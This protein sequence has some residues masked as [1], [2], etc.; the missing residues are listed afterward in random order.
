MS[1]LDEEKL[2]VK[3]HTGPFR[4]TFFTVPIKKRHLFFPRSPSPPPETQSLPTIDYETG[5]PPTNLTDKGSHDISEAPKHHD[6]IRDDC[7]DRKQVESGLQDTFSDEKLVSFK[8]IEGSSELVSRGDLAM[9]EENLDSKNNSDEA[10]ASEKISGDSSFEKLHNRGSVRREQLELHD[11]CLWNKEKLDAHDLQK[12]NVLSGSNTVSTQSSLHRS[13]WDLNMTM[14]AWEES[15]SDSATKNPECDGNGGPGFS[16]LFGRNRPSACSTREE[17]DAS[18]PKFCEPNNLSNDTFLSL[19]TS[20]KSGPRVYN[21]EAEAYLDLCLKPSFIPKSNFS[22]KNLFNVGTLDSLKCL[23]LSVNPSSTPETKKYICGAVK[24]QTHVGI[25]ERKAE[26]FILKPIKSESC[27]I[28]EASRIIAPGLVNSASVAAIKE[29]P[30]EDRDQ[31]QDHSMAKETR[32]SHLRSYGHN[33]LE[34][35]KFMDSNAKPDSHMKDGILQ[36]PRECP[37]QLKCEVD[38]MVQVMQDADKGSKSISIN[39]SSNEGSEHADLFIKHQSEEGQN[40][41]LQNESWE[42]DKTANLQEELSI[43]GTLAEN[44]ADEKS[45]AVSRLSLSETD[46]KTELGAETYLNADV[47]ECIQTCKDLSFPFE[48]EECDNECDPDSPHAID[49]VIG[50]VFEKGEVDS[51]GFEDGELRDEA[52]LRANAGS[53][54]VDA[55]EKSDDI[56]SR[57]PDDSAAVSSL[58]ERGKH[59]AVESP[60]MSKDPGTV[61]CVNNADPSVAADLQESSSVTGDSGRREMG[62]TTRKMPRDSLRKDKMSEWKTKFDR[63][64]T[65]V[66]IDKKGDGS[67]AAENCGG[68]IESS[69]P[70]SSDSKRDAFTGGCSGRIINLNSASSRNMKR[71]HESSLSSRIEREKSADKSF[72]RQKYRF[73]RSRDGDP[74]VRY[75]KIGNDKQR[76]LACGRRRSGSVHMRVKGGSNLSPS[77][78]RD[79]RQ[80]NQFG[81]RNFDLNYT[82]DQ[83]HVHDDFR[84]SRPIPPSEVSMNSMMDASIPRRIS[85]KVSDHTGEV[86]SELG[87][88]SQPKSR[89]TMPDRA[90]SHDRIPAHRERLS[91]SP[92]SRGMSPSHWPPH[93][94][95]EGFSGQTDMVQCRSGAPAVMQES[96]RSTCQQRLTE[97]IFGRRRVSGHGSRPHED[98]M[99]AGS[100]REHDFP[101]KDFS[102]KIYPRQITD[103]YYGPSFARGQ[104]RELPVGRESAV[105]RRYGEACDPVR[106]RQRCIG[107][108]EDFSFHVEGCPPRSYGYHGEGHQGFNR[109]G[110]SSKVGGRFKN[111]LGNPSKRYRGMEQEQHDADGFRH[112]AELGWND[113]GFN[114]ERPRNSRY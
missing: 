28:G 104:I 54:L 35:A 71:I 98:M 106:Y 22:Y 95:P 113:S 62:R 75:H 99:E 56:C 101:R 24:S 89:R 73:G 85:R 100:S 52:S 29:E 44:A 61:E 82:R 79:E 83:M 42:D 114:N 86:H 15:P 12:I 64:P 80:L 109:G 31:S 76:G 69:F 72:K 7:N 34:S 110:C 66:N 45:E 25:Q 53:H 78:V 4:D 30:V 47:I 92:R 11:P 94:A 65:I 60:E 88:V 3:L 57:G 81:G 2:G 37:K 102:H 41:N 38:S 58:P 32:D 112:L 26:T 63:D 90:Q 18:P 14:D 9:E 27:E 6:L 36:T 70:L 43:S 8:G 39:Q 103:E 87:Y 67:G 48:E 49:G 17:S 111:R 107:N 77:R 59:L 16:S 50:A 46:S 105:R 84:Y 21:S 93:T 96:M 23:S 108:D 13:R 51:R 5:D 74:S 68:H 40:M 55:I 97:E 91:L 19:H 1:S 33:L 20:P 10:F